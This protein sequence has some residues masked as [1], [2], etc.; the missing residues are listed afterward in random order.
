MS[1]IDPT[2]STE[3]ALPPLLLL[4]THRAV[5]SYLQIVGEQHQ[6]VSRHMEL[7]TAK[8]KELQLKQGLVLGPLQV[9]APQQPV[10]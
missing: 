9:G 8:I 2:T 1:A 3:Q 7:F 6:L 10:S 5:L 4:Y